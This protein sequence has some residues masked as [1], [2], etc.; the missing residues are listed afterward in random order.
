MYETF[1]EVTSRSLNQALAEHGVSLEDSAIERLMKRY[2][3]LSP[4]ADVLPCLQS[5]AKKP[6]IRCVIFSN[7]TKLMIA[8]S[9]NGAQDIR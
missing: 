2:D 3:G 7:G 6:H 8:N 9:V 4:F 1:F 5:L